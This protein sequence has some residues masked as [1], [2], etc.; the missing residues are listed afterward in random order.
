[1]YLG[2]DI[3]TSGVKAVLVDETQNIVD[4][5]TAPLTVNRPQALWSEQNPLSVIGGGARS[6]YRGKILSAAFNVPLNYRGGAAVGP[7]FGAAHLV[8]LSVTDEAV[9]E[10]C[11]PPNIEHTITPDSDLRD[12]YAARRQTFRK[13]YEQTKEFTS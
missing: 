11:T 4:Q 1:M 6:H 2:L 5:A 10:I 8:R 12:H 13:L 7:A 9:S 3:G